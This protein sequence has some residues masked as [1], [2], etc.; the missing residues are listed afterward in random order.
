[1]G[2]QHLKPDV[3]AGCLTWLVPAQFAVIL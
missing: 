1:M 2:K 3:Q